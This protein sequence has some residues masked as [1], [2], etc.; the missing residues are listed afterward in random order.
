MANPMV[1]FEERN[2]TPSQVESLDQRRRLGQL[3]LVL[4]VQFLLIAIFV[5]LWAGQDLT[6]SP[7][8]KRPMA[9]WDAL[10]FI[11]SIVFLIKGVR[12]RRGV[13]EFFSY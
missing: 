5:T 12:M 9:Y 7:G 8:W 13:N 3:F 11:L 2:L 4:G 6:Y 10:L 1:P